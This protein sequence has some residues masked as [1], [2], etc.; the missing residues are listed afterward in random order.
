MR[1]D[2]YSTPQSGKENHQVQPAKELADKV[3]H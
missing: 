3:N 2:V 1:L